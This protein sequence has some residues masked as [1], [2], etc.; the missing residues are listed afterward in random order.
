[1]WA[2]VQHL[3]EGRPH[4]NSNESTPIHTSP[5]PVWADEQ[6][7][8]EVRLRAVQPIVQLRGIVLVEMSPDAGLPAGGHVCGVLQVWIRLQPHAPSLPPPSP[9]QTRRYCSMRVV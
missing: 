9:H 5:S 3:M 4:T 7:L 8:M 6:H 1:M 2:D